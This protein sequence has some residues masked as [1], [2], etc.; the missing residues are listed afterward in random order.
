[1][2]RQAPPSTPPKAQ[3]KG[4]T[5]P[6]EF[7]WPKGVSGNPGG[8]PKKVPTLRDAA[9]EILAG[10]TAHPHTGEEV[11][12]LDLLAEMLIRSALHKPHDAM[13]LAR[14]LEGAHPPPPIV[15]AE[16]EDD[17]VTKDQAILDA[18]LQRLLRRERLAKGRKG[19]IAE[20][21]GDQDG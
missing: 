13:Q 6:K 11:T 9:L 4:G 18:A 15:E 14:W 17:G 10:K 8:R 1:M 12:K 21:E 3:R 2:S 20:D 5:P 16:P 7:Q 19:K